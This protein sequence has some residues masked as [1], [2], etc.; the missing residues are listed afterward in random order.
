[1]I[2]GLIFFSAWKFS[3]TFGTFSHI[4]KL[5][6]LRIFLQAFKTEQRVIWNFVFLNVVARAI[7]SSD[8]ISYQIHFCGDYG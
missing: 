1:M 8:K 2:P 3:F 7:F 4:S 6:S 5:F